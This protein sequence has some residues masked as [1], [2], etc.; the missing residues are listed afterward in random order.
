M[1]LLRS[2]SYVEI[3]RA[4]PRAIDGDSRREVSESFWLKLC[5]SPSTGHPTLG[6]RSCP[7]FSGA[8]YLCEML[9]QRKVV[10]LAPGATGYGKGPQFGVNSLQSGRIDVAKHLCNIIGLPQRVEG[11]SS[12]DVGDD[13]FAVPHKID[14]AS[15]GPAASTV[16]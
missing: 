9:E 8:A 15:Q 14:D 2:R 11:V 12:R 10:I 5:V 7:Q 4:V 6:K 1:N 3:A 13:R 16:P